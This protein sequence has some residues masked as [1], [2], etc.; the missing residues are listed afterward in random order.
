MPNFMGLC[1]T[2]T[3]TPPCKNIFKK[4]GLIVHYQIIVSKEDTM[5][6]LSLL[7]VPRQAL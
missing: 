1:Q 5:K 6:E 4:K 2:M 3:L 7:I